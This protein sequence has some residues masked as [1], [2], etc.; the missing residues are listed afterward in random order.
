MTDD[1]SK[2]LLERLED[3]HVHPVPRWIILARRFVLALVSV[4]TFLCGA[5]LFSLIVLAVMHVD[6]AFLRASSFGPMLH[7]AVNY[8]PGAWILLFLAFLF[9]ELFVLRSQ[10]RA[11]RYTWY[12]IG[13][14]VLFFVVLVGLGL[15]ASNIPHRV[16]SSFDRLPA[17][18]QP[19]MR[20]GAPLPRPEDGVLFGR[21]LDISPSSLSLEDPLRHRWEV[22]SKNNELLSQPFIQREQFILIQGDMERPGLFY[23]RTIK[24]HTPPTNRTRPANF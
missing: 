15:Y 4:L 9:V 13:G 16:E 12:S 10:A 8:V 7:L 18:M 22:R 14:F 20:R 2:R 3:E 24:P 5:L 23:A 6:P 17:R 19:W 11:Y 21:V 1:F